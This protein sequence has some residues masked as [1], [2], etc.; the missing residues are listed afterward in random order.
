[1]DKDKEDSVRATPVVPRAFPIRQSDLITHGFTEDCPGCKAIIRGQQHHQKHSDACR[2]RMTKLMKET[3]K[4]GEASK[5]GQSEF[6]R[7]GD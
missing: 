1:M 4:V 7:R 6:R 3:P 2:E 5:K